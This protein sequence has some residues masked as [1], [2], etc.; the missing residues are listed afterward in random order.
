MDHEDL[1]KRTDEFA[2]RVHAFTKPLL[3]SVHWQDDARQLRRAAKGLRMNY[4]AAGVGRTH[5]EFTAKLGVAREEADES[6]G[7][8]QF[9]FDT[10]FQGNSELRILRNEAAELRNIMAASYATAKQNDESDGD[11]PVAHRKRRRR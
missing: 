1:K 10:E 4:R 7:W 2:R 6:L 11:E 5:R 8:L 9:W 3:K